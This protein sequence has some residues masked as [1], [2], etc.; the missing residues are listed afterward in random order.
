MPSYVRELGP[1]SKEL[2]RRVIWDTDRQLIISDEVVHGRAT[3]LSLRSH[4]PVDVLN[5]KIQY[6]K[7]G[8]ELL[9]SD[10]SRDYTDPPTDYEGMM[11][12]G[13]SSDEEMIPATLEIIQRSLPVRRKANRSQ[14]RL[15]KDERRRRWLAPGIKSGQHHLPTP[16]C[17]PVALG[18]QP[19][20]D[21]TV[22]TKRLITD[23]TRARSI[24]HL[25][26]HNRPCATCEGCQAR[27]RQKKHH[28]GAF[29]A[30][31][32]DRTMI[33]AMDQ[34]TV[35]DF[36]YTEGYGGFR[37]GIVF[38]YLRTDYWVSIPLRTMGCSDAHA[39]FRQFCIMHQLRKDDVAVYC[40]VHQSLRQICYIEG[41]PVEH[42][43]PARPDA[44]TLIER[45]IGL[46]LSCH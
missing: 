13:E 4:L 2:A 31:P 18:P 40:D 39:G 26:C 6:Y 14:R 17:A 16:V 29:E 23:R 33:I 9:G 30:S 35:Q 22:I 45:K 15:T 7:K 12:L 25:L 20:E 41:I 24:D 34:L 8:T 32:K 27:S 19:D 43:P 36:D 38:C 21:G 37:Y 10:Y 1:L 42:P 44:N 11:G 46:A 28:K 5:I 3:L